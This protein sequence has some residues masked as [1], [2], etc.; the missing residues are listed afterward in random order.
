MDIEI[1]V[2]SPVNAVGIYQLMS[3][4]IKKNGC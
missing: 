1:H 2:F 3:I 4:G